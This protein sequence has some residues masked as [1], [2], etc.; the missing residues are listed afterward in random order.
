[1]CRA[2]RLDSDSLEVLVC[3]RADGSTLAA[4]AE[5]AQVAPAL[6]SASGDGAGVALGEAVLDLVY[7]MGTYSQPLAW[8]DPDQKA[9]VGVPVFIDA[10]RNSLRLIFYGTGFRRSDPAGLWVRVGKQDFWVV[11]AGPAKDR[12]GVDQVTI[13]A[14]STLGLRD[15]VEV[16]L[17]A[18]ELVSNPVTINIASYS[19]T[20]PLII[21]SVSPSRIRAGQWTSSFTVGGWLPKDPATIQI[22]PSQGLE[23]KDPKASSAGLISAGLSVAQ[24]ASPGTRQVSVLTANQQSNSLP[25]EV[26]PRGRAPE[27]SNF[28]LLSVSYDKSRNQASVSAQFDFKDPDGDIVSSPQEGMSAAVN[29][30]SWGY[31]WYYPNPVGRIFAANCTVGGNG[32]YLNKLSLTSGTITFTQTYSPA[33]RWL[34]DDDVKEVRL[35]LSDSAHNVSNVIKFNSRWYCY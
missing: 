8:Y 3:S 13:G 11:S 32:S 22:L 2:L 19:D 28:R 4:R 5:V 34:V 6:F 21:S 27:I 30:E 15:D 33:P 18:G 17:V 9:Y 31:T 29:F 20:S 16:R 26:L 12:P 23:L 10:W 35:T 1:M 14:F 7:G 24:D 25:L